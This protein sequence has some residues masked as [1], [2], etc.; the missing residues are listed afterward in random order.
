[1]VAQPKE[2]TTAT[3]NLA[4]SKDRSEL[5]ICSEDDM[6]IWS[7]DRKLKDSPVKFEASNGQQP[8][9]MQEESGNSDDDQS[10]GR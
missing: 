8:S 1:M 3:A 9:N 6:K 2:G 10:R 4:V 5:T 7:V